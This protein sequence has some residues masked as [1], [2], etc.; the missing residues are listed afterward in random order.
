M[1]KILKMG[2]NN[3]MGCNGIREEK[4]TWKIGNISNIGDV[5]TNSRFIKIGNEGG[6]R[7]F[8]RIGNIGEIRNIGKVRNVRTIAMSWKL[9][10]IS[11]IGIRGKIRENWETRI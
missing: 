3:K 1:G 8:P 2:Y 7:N 6:E 5:R 10:N 11:E 9:G 4:N